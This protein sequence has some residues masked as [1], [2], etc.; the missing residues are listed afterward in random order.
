MAASARRSMLPIEPRSERTYPMESRAPRFLWRERDMQRAQSLVGQDFAEISSCTR[1]VYVSHSFVGIKLDSII[2]AQRRQRR[3]L[4][5]GS[6][7]L[8][9]CMH[10]KPVAGSSQYRPRLTGSPLGCRDGATNSR[11]VSLPR[12]WR[13]PLPLLDLACHKDAA[14][15]KKNTDSKIS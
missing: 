13:L 1:N 10:T 9:G 4:L 2:I 14:R 12:T 5:V 6:E 3:S 11:G 7:S 15:S 8:D